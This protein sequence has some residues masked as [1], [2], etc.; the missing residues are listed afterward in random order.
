MRPFFEPHHM[1][2][3]DCGA[4]VAR[5]QRSIHVCDAGRLIDFQMF[6]LRDEV[7]AFDGA[8]DA[9][10]ASPQGQFDAWYAARRRAA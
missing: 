10:L 1:P 8:L 7:A 3:S 9:Y 5:P 2:C 6:Q 4:S